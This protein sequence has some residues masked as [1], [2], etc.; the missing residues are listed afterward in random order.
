MINRGWLVG[1]G[2][3]REGKRRL[4][5]ELECNYPD[6]LARD[7]ASAFPGAGSP[8]EVIGKRRGGGRERNHEPNLLLTFLLDP[9]RPPNRYRVPCAIGKQGHRNG[10]GFQGEKNT[11]YAAA[12]GSM[13]VQPFAA[14]F[15]SERGGGEKKKMYSAHGKIGFH[16]GK[17]RGF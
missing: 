7:P 9:T 12:V 6:R 17:E 1:R 13:S 10:E 14:C 8:G 16:K 15:G 4:F 11:M 3:K 2:G 5:S